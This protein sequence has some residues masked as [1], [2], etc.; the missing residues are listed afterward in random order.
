[1]GSVAS[2][3]LD[4]HKMFSKAGKARVAVARERS[5]RRAARAARKARLTG[6]Q[7]FMDTTTVTVPAFPPRRRAL[8]PAAHPA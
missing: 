8:L 3:P 1:M 7:P 2:V 5:R 6:R 4:I